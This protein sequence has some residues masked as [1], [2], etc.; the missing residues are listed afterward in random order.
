[1][2]NSNKDKI[3]LVVYDE[4]GIVI[5]RKILTEQQIK[6]IDKSNFAVCCITENSD[7]EITIA[8]H[9]KI[10]KVENLPRHQVTLDQW[11]AMG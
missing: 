4:I 5:D 1:M 8:L 3:Q 7:N 2:F 9:P 11:C 10:H 6:G